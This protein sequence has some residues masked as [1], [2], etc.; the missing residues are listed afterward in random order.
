M[1]EIMDCSIMES[2]ATYFPLQLYLITISILSL[3]NIPLMIYLIFRIF[4]NSLYHINARILLL[5]HIFSLLIHSIDR[6]LYHG[7]EIYKYLIIL[8]TVSSAC[9]ILSSPE[10]CF[11][12]RIIFNC[13]LWF[14][15]CSTPVLIIERCMA[16]WKISTWQK[17]RFSWIWMIGIQIMFCSVFAAMVYWHFKL[18]TVKYYCLATNYGFPLNSVISA[19]FSNSFNLVSIC[20]FHYLLRKNER[21]REKLHI[22]GS[23]LTNRYQVEESLRILETL[24]YPIYCMFLLPFLYNSIIFVV[25]INSTSMSLPFFYFIFELAICVP[26]Y[27]FIFAC[28]FIFSENRVA[29]RQTKQLKSLMAIQPQAYFDRYQTSWS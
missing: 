19:A 28:V 25:L 8:P 5:V 22:S 16:T 29:Q 1:S 20:I 24:E 9:D 21:I 4:Q 12:F 10:R 3:I 7:S 14:A 2:V 17:D 26:E 15:N 18:G 13:S 23:T 11:G 6:V 27:A